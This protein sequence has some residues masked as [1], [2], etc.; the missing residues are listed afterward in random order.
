MCYNFLLVPTPPSLDVR[1]FFMFHAR[2]PPRE[3]THIIFSRFSY[4][5]RLCYIEILEPCN[6]YSYK[7]WWHFSFS[8]SDQLDTHIKLFFRLLLCRS[9]LY[10]AK[11]QTSRK[12]K[13]CWNIKYEKKV[14]TVNNSININKVNNHLLSYL[15]EHFVLKRFSLCWSNL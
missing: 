10:Y 14:W 13:N 5:C 4:V 15:T 2:L 3:I 11:W 7:I 6:H 8:M 12:L 1:L 9:T